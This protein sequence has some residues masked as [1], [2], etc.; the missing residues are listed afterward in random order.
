MSLAELK[1]L[2]TALLVRVS[3]LTVVAQREEIGRLTACWC[4]CAID[5]VRPRARGLESEAG[6]LYYSNAC[7]TGMG[8]PKSALTEG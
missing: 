3:E 1:A 7:F 4:Y 2:V 5:R 8:F 6:L